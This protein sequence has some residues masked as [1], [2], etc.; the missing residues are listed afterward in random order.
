M[1]LQRGG[2]DPLLPECELGS[3]TLPLGHQV[4]KDRPRLELAFTIDGSLGATLAALAREISEA[5]DS[6]PDGPEGDGEN[7]SAAGLGGVALV[8]GGELAVLV[9][10][11]WVATAVAAES[12]S[13]L[14]VVRIPVPV[15]VRQL[16]TA[17]DPH[18]FCPPTSI[19]IASGTT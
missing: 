17:A 12:G 1:L 7:E 19:W 16:S 18:Q 3:G 9:S 8:A 5:D 13:A 14:Q 11:A 10:A 2:G 4:S 15:E 6:C